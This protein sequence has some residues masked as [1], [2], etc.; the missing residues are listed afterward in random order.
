MTIINSINV[1]RRLDGLSKK[2]IV[3]KKINGHNKIG[4][5]IERFKNLNHLGNVSDLKY[6]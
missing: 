2:K 5:K 3:V 1:M 4:S 6:A